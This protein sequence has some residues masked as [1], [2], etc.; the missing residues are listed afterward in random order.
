MF[1]VSVLFQPH[2]T[3]CYYTLQAIVLSRHCHGCSRC[4][5][6]F[7][8]PYCRGLLGL[9][10]RPHN[11]RVTVCAACGHARHPQRTPPSRAGSY[12][13]HPFSRQLGAVSGPHCSVQR[14]DNNGAFTAHAI[15]KLVSFDRNPQ[16]ESSVLLSMD[17]C[18]MRIHSLCR[19]YR[20]PPATF[21][22]WCY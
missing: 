13:W 16:A 10:G 19:V 15:C 20:L 5:Q 2:C 11:A 18:L 8:E 21:C 4:C 7:G 17:A 22:G 3:R 9:V 6:T 12:S 1:A 14:I